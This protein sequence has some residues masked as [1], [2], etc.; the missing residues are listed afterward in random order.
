MVS[1]HKLRSGCALQT[2]IH[3][4][5]S[6]S[7]PSRKTCGAMIIAAALAHASLEGL[8]SAGAT[9]VSSVGFPCA[10]RAG[11]AEARHNATVRIANADL[12]NVSPS[13]RRCFCLGHD[14]GYSWRSRKSDISARR[15]GQVNGRRGGGS[16]SRSSGPR[17]RPEIARADSRAWDRDRWADPAARFAPEHRETPG[18]RPFGSSSS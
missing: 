2:L 10:A 14:F 3:P 18:L 15:Q 11:M 4:G 17:C 6:L 9:S 16:S 5:S 1:L 13:R 8:G 7:S 12:M